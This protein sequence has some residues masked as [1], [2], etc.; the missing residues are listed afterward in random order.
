MN[1]NTEVQLGNLYDMNKQIMDQIAEPIHEL[2]LPPYQ[3][4]IENWFN[5]KVDSY[6]M[7]LCHERRDYT[8]FHL[9]EKANPNP[10]SL[11]A[12]ELINCLL[13]R[14]DILSIEQ[15]E[16]EQAWE[17]WLRIDKKSCCYYLFPYDSGVIEV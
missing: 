3:L 7:L 13:D 16:D 6:A 14:G 10:P 17:I 12:R 15:T 1:R 9:Y 5:W 11:A 2:A 4:K 8:V